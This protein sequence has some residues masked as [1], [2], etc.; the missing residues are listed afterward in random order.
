MDQYI[1]EEGK[2]IAQQLIQIRRDIH[3][4]PELGMEEKRTAK[5]V[6]DL[7]KGLRMQVQEGICQTGV[8][9]LLKGQHPGPTIAFRADM[10]ALQLQEENHVPYRSTIS[11]KM[12]ACGHD[13]HVAILLG[14]AMILSTIKEH[15]HGQ[16]KFVFQPAEEQG[17]TGGAQYLIEEGVL[18]NPPV[19]AM[20]GYHIFPHIPMG[21]V[22]L[23]YGLM[24]AASDKFKII[25]QGKGGHPGLPHQTIDAI[26]IGGYIITALQSIVSRNMDPLEPAVLSLGRISGGTRYNIISR[27]LKIEGTARTVTEKSRTLMEKRIRDLVLEICRG[28]GATG[29]VHY[30]NG[31]PYLENDHHMVLQIQKSL[32][33][34]LGADGIIQ[35]ERPLM[36]SEDFAYYA[37]RVPS[38]YFAMGGGVEGKDNFPNHHPCFDF[39]E[40][41]LELGATALSLIAFDYLNMENLTK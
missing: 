16:V 40:G 24:M 6:A 41:V 33:R 36:G 15:L 32:T 4:Y 7:L 23:K 20:I 14:A 12:H 19:D 18:E 1:K 25:V 2:R 30:Q 8:V 5:K 10:D 26:A 17:P 3:M 13:G 11:G 9:G 39:D 38:A 35:M 22:S 27:S 21:T 37:H 34:L 31:Y 28:M 29:E